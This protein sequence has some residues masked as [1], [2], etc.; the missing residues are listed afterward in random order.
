M[1]KGG[2]AGMMK[3]AQQ[4]Q[5]EVKKTQD[6]IK[7][8]NATGKAA[9]GGVEITINGEYLAT[10]IKIDEKLMDDKEMLEDLIL[11]AINDAS[12]QMTAISAKQMKGVA[13]GMNL[14]F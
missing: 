9:G 12:Q 6:Y 7:T 5:E 10:N 14:P 2:M 8:L 1:F 13:G 11:T 3:K 4:M